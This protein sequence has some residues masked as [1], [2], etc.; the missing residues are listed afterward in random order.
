[1]NMQPHKQQAQDMSQR[2]KDEQQAKNTQTQ[3]GQR[4]NPMQLGK[5][6]VSQIQQMLNKKDYSALSV[7]GIWGPETAEALRN[8][9]RRNGIHANGHLTQQTLAKLGVNWVNEKQQPSTVGAGSTSSSQNAMSKPSQTGA[10]QNAMSKSG[11]S[12]TTGMDS[13]QNEINQS[14]GTSASG[15]ADMNKYQPNQ[16]KSGPSG[17]QSG[18]S[19]Q[20]SQ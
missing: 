3:A 13:Q 16:N 12:A 4:V 11:S 5:Q 7:D 9:Q 18:A 20:K 17:M 14:S 10:S 2:N 15:Q 1:M 8:F 6:Q 19:N